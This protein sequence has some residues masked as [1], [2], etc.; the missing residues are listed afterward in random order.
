MNVIQAGVIVFVDAYEA[1]VSFYEHT[2][3]LPVVARL[4]VLTIFAV[5]ASYLEIE[6]GG[7][8]SQPLK[9]RANNPTVLRF[10]VLDIEAASQDLRSAGVAVKRMSHD[11]GETAICVDPDG[12]LVEF[13]LHAPEHT[14]LNPREA[15]RL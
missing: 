5:G 15:D 13:K 6:Q 3:L 10:D 7:P 4:D 11:W 2:L 12:N 9:S 1:C 8:S 14:V